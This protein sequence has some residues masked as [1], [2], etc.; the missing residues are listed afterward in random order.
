MLAKCRP[1]TARE[2]TTEELRCEPYRHAPPC[3]MAA[4]LTLSLSFRCGLVPVLSL[5]HTSGYLSWLSSL[6]TDAG[7]RAALP[8]DLY[9]TPHTP[10]AAR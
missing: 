3:T 9:A 8:P 4:S 1:V 7:A 10:K 2:A 5:V 6:A